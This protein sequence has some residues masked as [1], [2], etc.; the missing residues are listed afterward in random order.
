MFQVTTTL[1][2]PHDPITK[3]KLAKF[4]KVPK[5]AEEIKAIQEEKEKAKAAAAAEEAKKD[6]GKK[7]KDKKKKKEDDA[8]KEEDLY[9]FEPVPLEK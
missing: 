3:A 4:N 5:S 7:K 8:P 6:E 9:N 2:E 1:P